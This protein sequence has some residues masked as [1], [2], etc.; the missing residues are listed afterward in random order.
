[1]HVVHVMSITRSTAYQSPVRQ[2]DSTRRIEELTSRTRNPRTRRPAAAAST[3]ACDFRTFRSRYVARSSAHSH[4]LSPPSYVP[5]TRSAGASTNAVVCSSGCS[6]ESESWKRTSKRS[7]RA[8]V[9]PGV[10]VPLPAGAG[11]VIGEYENAS[12]S[13]ESCAGKP[14]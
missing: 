14:R 7:R 12:G 3:P 11:R 1:M 2:Q 6:C 9:Y 8:S 5:G 4:V 10:L 13:A